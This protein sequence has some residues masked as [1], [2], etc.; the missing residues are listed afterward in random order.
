[1]GRT[2]SAASGA[3]PAGP[4][5]EE[6]LVLSSDEVLHLRLAVPLDA[7]EG[8]PFGPVDRAPAAVRLAKAKATLVARGLVDPSTARPDREVLRRLL[9]VA[10]PDARIV[11]LRAGAGQG[12]RLI[13]AYHRA[14]AYVRHHRHGDRHHLGAPEEHVHV[15]D[16]IVRAFAPRRS[17][18]D[19]V[20]FELGAAEHA[21]LSVLVGESAAR[22]RA[23]ADG[24][25][26]L[27][28]PGSDVLD[29]SIDGA[30]ILPGRR[31]ARVA[32][33]LVGGGARPEVPSGDAWRAALDALARK[34][35]LHAVDGGWALRPYLRDL[36]LGLFSERR[37]VL[38]R[39]DFP[40]GDWV[41]RD[42]TFVPVAGSVFLLRATPAGGLAVRELDASTLFEAVDEAT[43]ESAS[44]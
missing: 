12:E 21:V 8:S 15:V 10:Q 43:R 22:D 36:A 13:D 27:D 37:H 41:V 42:A 30:I 32:P 35:V 25:L 11:L 23:D 44:P 17:S 33:S 7:G 5:D 2:R 19:F 6:A 3:A 38:T 39:F 20:R 9:I 31:I 24:P 1:M 28:R 16:A 34:D 18:G 4:A 40:G 14:G 29:P 26:A